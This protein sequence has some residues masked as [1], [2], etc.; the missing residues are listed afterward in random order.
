MVRIKQCSKLFQQIIHY[1]EKDTTC[2]WTW[3]PPLKKITLK[4]KKNSKTWNTWKWSK[5]KSLVNS[6]NCTL[7]EKWNLVEENF[8]SSSQLKHIQQQFSDPKTVSYSPQISPSLL[9]LLRLRFL[10]LVSYRKYP[11]FKDQI[12][13]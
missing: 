5:R 7:Q 4:Q 9:L 6:K 3:T 11:W 10:R 2:E 13:F 8:S 12:F 1:T